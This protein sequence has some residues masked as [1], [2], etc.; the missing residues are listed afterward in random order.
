MG[1]VDVAHPGRWAMSG[2]GGEATVESMASVSLILSSFPCFHRTPSQS[3]VDL[4]NRSRASLASYGLRVSRGD[5]LHL[6]A[7]CCL[8]VARVASDH[9]VL[10]QEMQR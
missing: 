10:I 5:A 1:G 8:T 9:A 3:A 2:T 6:G 4:P 7:V